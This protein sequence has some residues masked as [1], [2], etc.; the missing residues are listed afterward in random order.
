MSPHS[1][2]VTECPQRLQGELS[3]LRCLLTGIWEQAGWWQQDS[4]FQ[5]TDDESKAGKQNK[6]LNHMEAPL[7]LYPQPNH[8]PSPWGEQPL[9]PHRSFPS[10]LWSYAHP[11][12][13]RAPGHRN[14]LFHNSLMRAALALVKFFTL[15]T[16]F[17]KW[18]LLSVLPVFSLQTLNYLRIKKAKSQRHLLLPYF[19]CSGCCLNLLWILR[20]GL[21]VTLQRYLG[22]TAK[23]GGEPQWWLQ[24]MLWGERG[25]LSVGFIF[26][27][28]FLKYCHIQHS[29]SE[30]FKKEISSRWCLL[31]LILSS[32]NFLLSSSFNQDMDMAH[33]IKMGLQDSPFLYRQRDKK[34]FK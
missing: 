19:P 5:T 11:T 20:K 22:N 25:W 9:P 2:N 17:W 8:T 13:L 33:L 3:N 29:S 26:V 27:L 32:R 28:F 18:E 30:E 12:E 23:H 10:P 31:K 34:K 7:L 14:K 4:K 24:N 21:N 1:H 6:Q 15:K 16:H